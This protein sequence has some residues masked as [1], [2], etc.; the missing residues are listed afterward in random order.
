MKGT[1][2]KGSSGGW[3][4]GAESGSTFLSEDALSSSLS[5]KIRWNKTKNKIKTKRSL[6]LKVAYSIN[7]S[8]N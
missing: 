1:E 8:E 6:N 3:L 4:C 5:A 2:P 7:K